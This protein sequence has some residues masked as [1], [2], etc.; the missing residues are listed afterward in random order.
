[1]VLEHKRHLVGMG[2]VLCAFLPYCFALNLEVVLDQ[3]PVVKHRDGRR[4]DDF[5]V[6]EDW[7]VEDDIVA[8]PLPGWA[9]YVDQRWFLAVYSG[10]VAVGVSSVTVGVKHLYF[11]VTHQKDAAVAA[12]LAA[13]LDF[14]RRSPLNVQLAVAERLP[15]AD[16][17]GF[18]DYFHIFVCDLP[19][20]A[21]AILF[22][23]PFR[24]VLA[25]EENDSIGRRLT[26]LFSGGNNLW[27][28]TTHI[29]HL[30]GMLVRAARYRG[31]QHNG[32]G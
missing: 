31:E 19:P 20:G 8:L 15:G 2:V 12:V 3:D 22:R 28:R 18:F 27:Q 1:M 25:V 29:V 26:R 30:P 21:A 5:A 23:Y 17:A 14:C 32:N 9:R 6:L 4:L 13:A 11:V 7:A 24:E 16:V 10:G